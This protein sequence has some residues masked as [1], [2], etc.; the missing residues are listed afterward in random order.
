MIKILKNK[1]IAISF[2][3]FS[4][5]AFSQ[6][7]YLNNNADIEQR[8]ENAISL[9]TIEEKV[10]LCH[11]HST[12]GSAGVSRLGI[13]EL[14]MSDGPHGVREE[15]VWDGFDSA[16]FGNDSCMAFPSLTCL[17]ATFNLD[18]SYAYG[19]SLGEES[20]YRKKDVLLGPGVNIYRTPMSGR[21]FE[22]MGED[23]YLAAQMCVPYIKGVQKNKVAACI[24]H[25]A[26][27]NQEQ[28][29]LTVDVQVS[30]RALHEIYLPAFKAS[31]QE[32][33]V[34]SI[35]GSYNKYSGEFCSHNDKLINK[36]L[37]GDWGYDGVVISDWG[38][39]HDTY[40]AAKNGLDIEMCSYNPGVIKT[41]EDYYLARPFRQLL[42]DGKL[43]ISLLDEKV[44]RILRLIF[45]TTMSADRPYGSMDYAKHAEVARRI[46]EEGVVMLKNDNGFFPILPNQGKH[47]LVIGE[48]ANKKLTLGGGSSE[49]KAKYEISVL[50]GLKEVYGSDNVSYSQGYASGAY[51]YVVEQKPTI[52][53][54]SLKSDAL[55][56][57][58]LADVIIFVGGLN[59]NIYQDCENND[60]KEYK[61]PFGQDELIKELSKVNQNIAV[62]L[63]SG[64]A[65]E[66]S[67]VNNVPTILQAWYLGSE[68]GNALANIISGEVNPSGK[69][70]FSFAK[71]LSDSPAHSFDAE[72]Y[73]GSN[74][75]VVYKE[76]ILVGYRWHDTKKIPALFS[77]GHGLSYTQFEYSNL[78]FDK[79][80]Y[81]HDE[82]LTC[83]VTIKNAGKVAGFEVVQLYA[84]QKNA[85]VLRPVKE[86]KSF[87]K[88]FLQPGE[89]KVVTMELALSDLSYYDESVSD[90]ILDKD[91]YELLIGSSSVDIRLKGNIIIKK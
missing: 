14:W 37:K 10:A 3:L 44:K 60:R 59:K 51:H 16:K 33:G 83:Y 65:V 54:D 80:E 8:I 77:F 6:N 20:R 36:I 43:P 17:A 18:C 38:A 66:M 76:D 49:L 58:Q 79:K 19:V 46:A 29:R 71:K 39:T 86:L 24:K 2:S 41:F 25:F 1:I 47:I 61:L 74:G 12:F 26:V 27:N 55:A 9:M 13:P 81:A 85:K 50:D 28:D 5:T 40:Q 67:W 7:V 70:P 34:W 90:W 75:K 32:A 52:D 72:C 82:R 68:G 62:V 63:L 48:N 78:L 15:F 91:R 89:V 84:S 42:K 30:D 4:I 35:M 69:L 64:N 45:R 56:K 22:Y 88:V 21:N 53:L 73:P 57:A 31:V 11:A 87:R 23:P